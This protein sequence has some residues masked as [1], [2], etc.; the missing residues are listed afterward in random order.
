MAVQRILVKTRGVVP[1]VALA[2]GGGA[3]P[4][5]ST[6]LFESIGDATELGADAADRWFLLTSPLGLKTADI[7]LQDGHGEFV[8]ADGWRFAGSAFDMSEVAD[9]LAHFKLDG[10][11]GN[12]VGRS[13]GTFEDG[14]PAYGPGRLDQAAEFD[15]KRFINAGNVGEF[16]FLDKFT[17][18]A[19]VYPKGET[20]GYLLSRKTRAAREAG[21]G[22][23]LEAGNV[24]VNL[25]V[26]WLDDSIRVETENL[27]ILKQ[28]FFVPF[29]D[30]KIFAGSFSGESKWER[31]SQADELV[32]VLDGAATLTILTADGPQAL[33][34]YCVAVRS[35]LRGSTNRLVVW[36]AVISIVQRRTRIRHSPQRFSSWSI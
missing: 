4:L 33:A 28:F 29:R 30:G 25:V 26:R 13:A 7:L 19:W 27:E 11:T 32:Q 10:N 22:V 6:P 2:L 14:H 24:H 21:Y 36:S 17:L 20:G 18:A 1:D 34:A 3:V 23:T 15:G 5:A 31:H 35:A 16:G 8:S 12:E 9:L